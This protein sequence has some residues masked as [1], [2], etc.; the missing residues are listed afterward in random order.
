MFV[1]RLGAYTK[2]KV[3]ILEN[4]RACAIKLAGIKPGW[5]GLLGTNTKAY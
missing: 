1:G 4:V 2:G 3:L 5:K